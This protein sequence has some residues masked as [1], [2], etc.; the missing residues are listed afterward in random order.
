MPKKSPLRK[1]FEEQQTG[2][3]WT[4]EERLK[5]RD[6]EVRRL[7]DDMSTKHPEW[8]YSYIVSQIVKKVFLSER[9]IEAILRGE[10]RYAS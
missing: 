5:K 9:T 1:N 10:G 8:R 7:F 4:R 2:S 6:E 3:N